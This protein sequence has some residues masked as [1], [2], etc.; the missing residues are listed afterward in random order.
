MVRLLI[1][2]LGFPQPESK[3]VLMESH[4]GVSLGWYNRYQHSMRPFF[5]LKYIVEK[6]YILDKRYTFRSVLFKFA[7]SLLWGPAG[8]HRIFGRYPDTLKVKT[9]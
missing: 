6:Q 5:C 1:W 7:I 9:C 8:H 3:N 4:Q 2:A